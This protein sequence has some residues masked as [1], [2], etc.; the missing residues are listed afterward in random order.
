MTQIL[1]RL[2]AAVPPTGLPQTEL[3]GVTV[4]TV[5]NFIFALA[6]A[7]ALLMITLAGFK[8]ATSRGDANA[9]KSSK[10]TIVYAVVGL[11]I[12]MAAFSVVNFVFFKVKSP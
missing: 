3:D 8:Y 7:V 9:V 11:L 6:G 2:L 1:L 12:T 10:E 4:K 5:L